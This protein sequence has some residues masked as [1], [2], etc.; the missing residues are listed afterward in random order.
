MRGPA[1]GRAIVWV[2]EPGSLGDCLPFWTRRALKPLRLGSVP[3]LLIPAGQ[4]QHWVG[5]PQQLAYALER[6]AD[7][8]PDVALCSLSLSESE[9]RETA[10]LLGLQESSE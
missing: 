7:V 4:V 8:Q 3:A 2:S 1:T 5:F 9:L 10:A 6:P